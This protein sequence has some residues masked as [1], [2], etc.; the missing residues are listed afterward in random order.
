MNPL[1]NNMPPAFA[2][3]VKRYLDSYL[4]LSR[5]NI[6]LHHGPNE[7][8]FF[9]PFRASNSSCCSLQQTP[10]MFDWAAGMKFRET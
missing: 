7:Q 5:A 6:M 4:Y 8:A 9:N 2:R 1:S 3:K 10:P